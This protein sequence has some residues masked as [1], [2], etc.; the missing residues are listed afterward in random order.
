M[1][2]SKNVLV[3]KGSPEWGCW[4]NTVA[5]AAGVPTAHLVED[6]LREWAIRHSYRLPPRRTAP[7]ARV[8]DRDRDG[9]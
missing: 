8:K 7:R 5:L 2:I 4:L 9:R 1:A 6:A 3:M